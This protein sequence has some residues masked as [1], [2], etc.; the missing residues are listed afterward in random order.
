MPENTTLLDT[1]NIA[2]WTHGLTTSL[3]RRKSYRLVNA[4]AE[5][6]PIRSS[7][8]FSV[9]VSFVLASSTSLPVRH[10]QGGKKKRRKRGKEMKHVH[11]N[12]R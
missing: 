5:N 4:A 8:S 9:F 3:R 6:S 7:H 1:L 11:L 12:I 10:G 2:L